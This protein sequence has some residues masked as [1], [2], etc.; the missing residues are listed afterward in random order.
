LQPPEV[1]EAMRAIS[2]KLPEDLDRRLTELAE[3]RK[4]T[5]SALLREALETFAVRSARSVT[6]VAGELVGS[7]DG[8]EDLS[9]S[10]RHLAGYGR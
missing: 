8:P 9:T 7:L 5:R 1:L 2:L 10:Y 3:Q 6:S 4:T